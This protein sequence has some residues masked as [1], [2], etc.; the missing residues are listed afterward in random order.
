MKNIFFVLILILL[1]TACKSNQTELKSQ[2]K[3]TIMEE[4]KGTQKLVATV[5]TNMGTFEL[6]LFA[7]K[8]PRTVENF[9]GLAKKGY[10][11]GVIFHRIINGF[12]IQGGDPT[13]TGRGGES[14]WGGKFE[15]EFDPTLRHT[16]PGLLSMANSGPN[17]NGS[18]FFITLAPTPWLDNKH[19]I[20]GQVI[21]GMDV[22]DKIANVQVDQVYNKPYQEVKMLKVTISER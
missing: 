19:S 11:D 9:A 2:D 16:G 14:L 20:F 21:T 3:G 12:V 1:T 10:Y 7:D 22:I 13:G 8:A 18:Q 17:T 6:E 4:K 15:D 5:E